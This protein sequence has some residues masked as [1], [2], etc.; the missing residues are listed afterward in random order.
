MRFR[1]DGDK[2]WLLLT[3]V[4][5]MENRYV[6]K[7]KELEQLAATRLERGKWWENLAK[8]HGD[9]MNGKVKELEQK[10]AIAVE[11]LKEL[12]RG[13]IFPKSLITEALAKINHK[14]EK[15]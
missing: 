7:I 3:D 6:S 4:N 1:T 5:E 10:L 13:A 12:D 15:G 11:A 8:E 9:K 2:T 14:Q